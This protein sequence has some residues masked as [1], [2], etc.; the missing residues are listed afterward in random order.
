MTVIDQTRLPFALRGD[1]PRDD[2]K[3]RRR[4]SATMVVRGAPLIGAT[5][6]YGVALAMR[7]DASDARARRAPS[8]V[9]GGDAAD[10]GQPALG[11]RAH[12]ARAAAASRRASARRAPSPRR[13]AIADEDVALL[14]RHRRARRRADPRGRG[15]KARRA[16]QHPHP[17]QRRLARDRRLGHRAGADLRRARRRRARSMSGST[18]RGRATRAR[19]SP[20][21][22]SAPTACRT[23]S[24]A[25]NAGGHLMQHGQVDLCIVGSDRTTATGDVANK[26]GTYLKA[27]AAH[28]NGVPF[29]VALPSSTIDWSLRD[30]VR[31]IPIEER[32]GP[33]G[34]AYDRADRR[35][36][37]RDGRG[38]RARQ[39]GR[40]PRLRRDAGAARHRPHHRARRRRGEPR[41]ACS[42]SIPERARPPDATRRRCATRSSRVAQALD[43]AGFCPSKSGN[44]SARSGD[45]L[46]DHALGPALRGDDSPTTSSS[47][48][49]DGK[50]PRRRAPALLGMA[51]PHRDLQGAARTRRRSSTPIAAMAT[52][53]VLRAARHPGLPLHDRALRRPRRALRRLRD[54]RHAGARRQR[55]RG[56]RRPQGRAARQSRRHRARRD[57][58][59]RARDRRRG[60]EP[61]G[62]VSRRSSRRG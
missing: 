16:G 36:R 46:P 60:R 56:A 34:H 48:I 51:L 47:S 38:R 1:A 58:R 62:A 28:D 11:A 15:A 55:R 22:S 21:A 53:L 42:R 44:V 52:A 32:S 25:D 23:R 30:G 61:R 57:A 59:G 19:R 40:Q 4:R 20:P 2:A 27:L 6:A 49:S 29:Y 9:L 39:P 7:A 10:R 50:R 12:G 37:D 35:R 13:R 5:A 3:R 54:L 14:P 26:I 41:G 33:R 45:G 31:E 24:I 18:R 17:L 43:R 8:R